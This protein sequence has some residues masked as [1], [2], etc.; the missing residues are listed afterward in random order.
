MERDRAVEKPFSLL[1]MIVGA[2]PRILETN[3][4]IRTR[5]GHHHVSH[6]LH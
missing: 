2:I 3:L 6:N 5:F 1:G 4:S